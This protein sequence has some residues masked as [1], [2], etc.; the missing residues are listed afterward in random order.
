[1][2]G[3]DPDIWRRLAALG[4]TDTDAG[5]D[6]TG[7]DPEGAVT[8]KPGFVSGGKVQATSGEIFGLAQAT[9]A[10]QTI[11]WFGGGPVDEYYAVPNIADYNAWLRKDG[12]SNK[13][14]V[15]NTEVVSGFDCDDFSWV[16]RNRARMKHGWLAT[17]V[18]ANR[19]HA[20]SW[21]VVHQGDGVPVIIEIEPQTDEVFLDRRPGADLYA[22][23]GTVHLII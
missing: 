15:A 10:D 9:W 11:Q 19:K 21:A 5:P 1:M 12:T 14:Y 22:L 13:P 23:D 6:A 16:L 17:G 3:C 18:I 4:V 8:T 7:P 2:E 20:W